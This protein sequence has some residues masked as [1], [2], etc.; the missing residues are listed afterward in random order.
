MNVCIV[1]RMY[2][3][4]GWLSFGPCSVGPPSFTHRNI[5]NRKQQTMKSLGIL[6]LAGAASAAVIGKTTS[7]G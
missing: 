5:S 4:V 3:A 1:G 6:A 7:T 2:K